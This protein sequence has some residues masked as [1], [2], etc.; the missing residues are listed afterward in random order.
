MWAQ[1]FPA[2]VASTVHRQSM[3]WFGRTTPPAPFGVVPPP[4]RMLFLI[5]TS[6][7]ALPGVPQLTVGPEP[8]EVPHCTAM[9]TPPG[10]LG[11]RR[12][13]AP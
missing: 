3:I 5:S 1:F 7:V 13:R 6:F 10:K 11:A 4:L 9:R 2:T 8:F 12:V